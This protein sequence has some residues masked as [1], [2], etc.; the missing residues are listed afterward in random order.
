MGKNYTPKKITC[1]NK[2]GMRCRFRWMEMKEKRTVEKEEFVK[3]LKSK[4]KVDKVGEEE[5]N[6]SQSR[7]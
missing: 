4:A 5:K 2:K 3:Y 7:R 6:M 1:K